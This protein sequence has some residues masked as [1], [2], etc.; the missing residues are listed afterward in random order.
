MT[1]RKC[2]ACGLAL[3][4]P[5]GVYLSQWRRKTCSDACHRALI[6]SSNTRA[7]VAKTCERCGEDLRRRRNEKWAGFRRRRSCSLECAHL[8]GKKLCSDSDFVN[9]WNSGA[10][11]KDIATRLGMTTGGARARAHR[12]R[13][14]GETLKPK[15]TPRPARPASGRPGLGGGRARSVDVHGMMLTRAE[16]ASMLAVPKQTIDYRI[17][18]GLSAVARARK[19]PCP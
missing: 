1:A 2:G 8:L 15:R 11:V 4:K 17:N 3:Q 16:I 13:D 9:A 5:D 14:R 18:N 7:V 6:A 12:L 10:A 19:T